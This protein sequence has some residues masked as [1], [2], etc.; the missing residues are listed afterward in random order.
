[1]KTNTTTDSPSLR[2][3]EFESE[4][5]WDN[6]CLNGICEMKAGSFVSASEIKDT[7][8]SNM[9][10]CYGGNGLRGYTKTFTHEGMF[11][12]IGR[13]GA[14]CG[15]ITLVEEKFHATEHAVVSIPKNNVDVIWLYYQ[16]VLLNLNQYATGQAQP[17]LSVKNLNEIL[18]KIPKNF[19]EQ[20]KI[21]DCLSSLDDLINEETQLLDSLKTHKAGLLQNLFTVEEE[22]VPKYRFPEFE[23]DG[24]WEENSLS[25]VCNMK[26]GTFVSASEIKDVLK[27]NLY[28][29]YGGNGLRGFTK[30]Y[31]HNGIFP[32]IGR[33]GALCGNITLVKGEFHATEHAVVC[34]PN[35]NIDVIWLY[36]Q[37][38]L[39]DLNQYA[40][41][42]AQPG[43]SVKNLNNI[44]LRIPDNFKEQQKIANSLSSLDNFIQSQAEKIEILKEHKQGLIQQLFPVIEA[45]L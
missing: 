29:C 18:V 30:T 34:V 33:Q 37:L 5:G 42:Q 43:L 44:P 38:V 6:K 26:A 2:F 36:Y 21:A 9:Y 28:P 23:G 8:K 10:P 22:A 25:G 32:L 17:G 7:L 13:Q 19:R 20:Q 35:G 11:P 27:D 15:N 45:K 4:G 39:L 40:T 31:T 24:D 14:L 12:L 41:G 1:M 3:P 16:L